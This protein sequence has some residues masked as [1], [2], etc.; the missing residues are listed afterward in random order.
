MNFKINSFFAVIILC[1]LGTVIVF[2][3]GYHYKYKDKKGAVVFTDDLS[4]VPVDQRE[5]VT[6]YKTVKSKKSSI[7][8]KKPVK[9]TAENDFEARR[10][11]LVIEQASLSKESKQLQI[12]KKMADTVQ[13][14]EECN[15]KVI[16]L[17]NR[18]K[19]YRKKLQEYNLELKQ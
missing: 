18:I 15:K 19:I 4:K 16:D 14:K 1:V 6:K 5:K 13:K 12:E 10:K 17:N 9:K 11:E 3:Q 7:T 8:K 2:A